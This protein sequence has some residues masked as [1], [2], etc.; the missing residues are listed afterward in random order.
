[1]VLGGRL[2][3]HHHKKQHFIKYYIEAIA[4]VKMDLPVPQKVENLMSS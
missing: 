3:S 2:K 1:M 4:N